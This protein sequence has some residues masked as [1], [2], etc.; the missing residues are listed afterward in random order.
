M[1]RKLVAIVLSIGV[2]WLVR[3]PSPSR[4]QAPPERR[5]VVLVHGFGA[6]WQSW[7]A[8]LGA[9]GYLA[10]IGR[11]GFAVGD[12]QVAGSLNTGNLLDPTQRTNTIAENAAI[13]GA[14]IDAVRDATGAPQVDLIAHSMGGLISR[15]YID[16]VMEK[17]TVAQL[18]MLGSPQLGTDCANLPAAAGLYLPATLELRPS[19]VSGLF[20]PQITRRHGVP[21]YIL[22]G[23][24][25]HERLR[26]PCT[27][28]PSDTVISRRS[29]RG[30]V[31]FSSEMPVLHT[32]MNRSPDVFARFVS[33]LLLRPTSEIPFGPDPTGP[34]PPA[35]PLQFTRVYTGH[36]AAGE[37]VTH[38]VHIDAVAVASFALYDPTRSLTVTVQG[39]G[40][41]TIRLD[42]ATHGLQV[43]DDP[44]TLLYL[45]YGFNDPRPG[46]WRVALRPTR[47]TPS[48]GATYALSTQYVGGATLEAT[49]STLLP[50]RGEEV[51]LSAVLRL[52]DDSLALREAV[53][54]IRA[55]DGSV[56]RL[57]LRPVADHYSAAWIPGHSGLHAID[58]TVVGTAP[59]DLTVERGAFLVVEVQPTSAHTR[60]RRLIVIGV[61]L[62]GFLAVLGGRSLR[63]RSRSL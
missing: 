16:R 13:L 42:P 55:P 8:Y 4:A 22:A 27:D 44:Q 46:P 21:F 40:G 35:P 37:A 11:E 30:T 52:G 10:G 57:S 20:N 7:E 60:T 29:A 17:R 41:N 59:G 62:L 18:I 63:R 5:P 34:D 15:Y 45:G 49:S 6:T 25:I 28:V 33:P 51:D 43:I 9:T 53:A 12:G 54:R 14:Y 24:P 23:T 50:T 3:L 1:N 31:G 58:L 2:L 32:D 39:A 19:Y 56:Q 36:V 47:R 61:L 38:T 48:G 26:S